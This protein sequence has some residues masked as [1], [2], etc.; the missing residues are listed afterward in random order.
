MSN[1]ESSPVPAPPRLAS[2]AWFVAGARVAF[3]VGLAH[4]G[5]VP[6]PVT[7]H[8][9]PVDAGTPAD[10]KAACDRLAELDCPEAQPTPEGGTCVDVCLNVEQSGYTTLDPLC[11]ARA[12]TCDAVQACIWEAQ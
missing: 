6:T 8:P 3:V 9:Q 5:C 1:R 7:P 12:T 10:C 4:P 11:L 2:L